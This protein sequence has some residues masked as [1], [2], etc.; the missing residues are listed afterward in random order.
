[1]KL[2]GLKH[3]Q[4]LE[5]DLDILIKKYAKLE[6]DDEN[7]IRSTIAFLCDYRKREWDDFCEESAQRTH[8]AIWGEGR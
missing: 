3:E 1:M 8:D 2:T 7:Y 4:K 6:G 5:K